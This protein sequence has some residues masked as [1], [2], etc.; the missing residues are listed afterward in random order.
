MPAK[1]DAGVEFLVLR[2]VSLV[3]HETHVGDNTEDIVFVLLVKRYG[4]VVVGGHQDL[5]TR[6]LSGFLLLLVES[7]ANCGTVLVENDIV[8]RRQI[9]RVVAHGILDQQYSL[10]AAAEDIVVGVHLVLEKLDDGD[11][12]VGGVIPAEDTVDIGSIRLRYLAEYLL[13]VAAEQHHRH[14]GAAG[15]RFVGEGKH[16]ELADIVHREREVELLPRFEKRER[17][18]RGLY[19]DD[20][21]RVAQVELEVVRRDE[22]LDVAVFFERVAVVVVA[23]KE[24]PSDPAL[25]QC[26]EILHTGQ[27]Y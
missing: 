5:R 4:V 10:Y 24:D 7:V 3:E 21:R 9:G 27:K 6:T 1:V 18:E 26:R 19:P 11:Y 16:V 25:H 14:P 13:G 23:D 22:R 17:F 20:G 2:D 12:E 8:E 15:F